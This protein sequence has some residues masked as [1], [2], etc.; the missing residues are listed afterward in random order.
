ML[1]IM[2]AHIP[3]ID[4]IC[5]ILIILSSILS[6]FNSCKDDKYNFEEEYIWVSHEYAYSE[7]GHGNIV[8]FLQIKILKD[9]SENNRTIHLSN[10]IGF[11]YEEGYSYI[12]YVKIEPNELAESVPE[13]YPVIYTHIS[14]ILKEKINN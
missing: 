9:S 6:L 4:R 14:T 3:F 11:N 10:I 7:N 1:V 12:L 5:L 13:A 8:R 2:F